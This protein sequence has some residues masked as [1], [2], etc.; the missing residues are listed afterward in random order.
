MY[1]ILS[2]LMHRIKWLCSI[3]GGA[4]FLPQRPQ[5]KMHARRKMQEGSSDF[6][7]LIKRTSYV[8]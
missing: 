2:Q 8:H 5:N 6:R 3:G 1:I 4:F 7:A